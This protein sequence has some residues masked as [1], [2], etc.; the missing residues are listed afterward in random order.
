MLPGISLDLKRDIWDDVG[1]LCQQFSYHI[2]RIDGPWC[3]NT[4]ALHKVFVLEIR[5]V[6]GR[7]VLYLVD[8]SR[9]EY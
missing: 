6:L 2:T 8:G 1:H 7:N 3:H 4:C 9:P 5:D